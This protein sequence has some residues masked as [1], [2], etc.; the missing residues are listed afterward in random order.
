M[1]AFDSPRTPKFCS[2][3]VGHRVLVTGMD[4]VAANAVASML[5]PRAVPVTP[6]AL[7]DRHVG[8]TPGRAEEQQISRTQELVIARVDGDWRAE[9]FLLVRVARYPNALASKG[10]LH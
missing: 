2:V 10:G 3:V 9:P 8:A 4:A 6:V 5:P 7:M 1:A